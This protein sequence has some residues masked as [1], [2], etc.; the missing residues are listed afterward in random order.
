MAYIPPVTVPQVSLFG[1]PNTTTTPSY[2]YGSVAPTTSS[3]NIWGSRGNPYLVAG[4]TYTPGSG[5]PIV[6]RPVTP[7]VAPVSSSDGDSFPDTS[8]NTAS[9]Y[10][11]RNGSTQTSLPFNFGGLVGGIFGGPIGG[12]LGNQAWESYMTNTPEEAAKVEVVDKGTYSPKNGWGAKTFADPIADLDPEEQYYQQTGEYNNVSPTASTYVDTG[13]KHFGTP[14]SFSDSTNADL[15]VTDGAV[16]WDSSGDTGTFSSAEMGQTNVTNYGGG[17][18]GVDVSAAQD[19]SEIVGVEVDDTS[20]SD[21]SSD[22]D[23]SYIAT[24]ATQALGEE[25][26][27]VFNN[28][29]DYMSSWHPTFKT[30]YGRYRVTAPKIVKA[31]DKK[32]NSKELYKEIWDKHLN[33]IFKLIKE[34]P[35]NPKALSDYKIMVKELMNKYIKTGDK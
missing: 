32:E 8:M 7:V 14:T 13:P 4:P 28:W 35:D 15:G 24:A 29:R 33:P 25:G 20:S 1:T 21:S 3:Y 34:D 17:Y 16:S 5:A 27:Q 12:Y 6:P 19:G 31:I 30:S 26:L 2:T 9:G 18:Y 11:E 10:N 23:G 22:S